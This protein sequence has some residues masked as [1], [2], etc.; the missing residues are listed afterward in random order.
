MAKTPK[1]KAVNT[2]KHDIE[3]FRDVVARHGCYK[4]DLDNF[5]EALLEKH[6]NPLFDPD[7][8]KWHA[9]VTDDNGEVL[10]TFGT[11]A[12]TEAPGEPEPVTTAPGA[13]RG[14]RSQIH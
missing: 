11:P 9:T 3:E 6:A 12:P 1:P 4:K 5:A 2:R 14:N 8:V 13:K 7:R 10:A